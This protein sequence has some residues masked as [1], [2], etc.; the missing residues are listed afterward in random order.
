MVSSLG[1]RS[2]LIHNTAVVFAGLA[3]NQLLQVVGSVVL[4]RILPTATL[5][6]QVSIMLQVLGM[7]GLFLNLGLNTAL[8]YV[9]SRHGRK[10]IMVSYGLTLTASIAAAVLISAALALLAPWIGNLYHSPAIAGAIA[11]GSLMLIMN[12]AINVG[13][14]LFS[15]A[16]R[17]IVQSVLMVL[18]TFFSTVGMIVGAV[19]APGQTSVPLYVSAGMC[20]TDLLTVAIVLTWIHRDYCAPLFVRIRARTLKSLLKYGIPIWAGNIAKSFQQ[21]FLIVVTGAASVVAAGYLNNAMKIVGFLNIVTWAFN[22]VALPFLSEVA[23][24]PRDASARATLCFRYNNF[25]LFPLTLLILL[26]PHFITLSLFGP[27]YMTPESVAF[28][29]VT[30]LGVLMSSIS[31]LG[32]TLLSG[33][34]HPRANFWTM[35]VSG[36]PVL[37]LAPLAIAHNPLLG[38]WVY[39]LGW[40]LSG[41]SLLWFLVRDGLVVDWRRAFGEPLIPTVVAFVAVMI[42]RRII[43]VRVVLMILE[44]ILVAL[45]TWRLERSPLWEKGN[46]EDR[47]GTLPGGP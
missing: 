25:I 27:R 42:M 38:C 11:L 39:A 17:F 45:L 9:V 2:Y 32:G 34:G 46:A 29:S 47:C 10:A 31:R 16:R 23:N 6:G 20:A 3:V 21:S 8:I 33:I 18:I 41:V 44:G 22:I 37:L 1:V 40:T 36:G 35:I 28:L 13:V 30:A 14:A 26:F 12:S 4:A 7:G 5:F 43:D 19:L 24:L 15:G